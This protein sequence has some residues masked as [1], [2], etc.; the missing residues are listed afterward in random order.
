MSHY[1]YTYKLAFEEDGESWN[2]YLN[3][4]FVFNCSFWFE[5]YKNRLEAEQ[6]LNKIGKIEDTHVEKTVYRSNKTIED[7]KRII[8][9]LERKE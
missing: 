5:G 6:I 4:E 3:N 1:N 8:H 2:V 9:D 7:I